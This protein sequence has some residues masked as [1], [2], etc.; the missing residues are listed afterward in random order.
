MSL[1]ASPSAIRMLP[2]GGLMVSGRGD[3]QQRVYF[4]GVSSVAQAAT[5]SLQPGDDKNGVN[6][7]VSTAAIRFGQGAVSREEREQPD[8]TSAVIRGRV[9][10]PGGRPIAGAIVR[11]IPAASTLAPLK[12]A[13]TDDQGEYQFV[14]PQAAEGAYRVA[15]NGQGYLGTEYGQRRASDPG[16]EITIESGEMRD[17]IVMT[18]QRPG[19]IM[20]RLFDENGNPVEGVALRASQVAA[21]AGSSS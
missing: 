1:F 3:P 6:F 9:L 5:F 14:L 11:L 18:L 16:E 20:G 2:D 12:L 21:A 17:R 19:A 13:F 4:P 7:T 8:K 15:A 10:R